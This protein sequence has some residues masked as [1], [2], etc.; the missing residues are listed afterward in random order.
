MILRE[1]RQGLQTISMEEDETRKWTAVAHKMGGGRIDAIVSNK[2]RKSYN[3]AADVLGALMEC[4]LLNEREHEARLLLDTYR[5]Q[6]YKRYSAFRA[7][8]KTVMNAS[9]LLKPYC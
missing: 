4:E 9:A 2:H 3:R 6:K 1:I 5:N 7:E 8:L